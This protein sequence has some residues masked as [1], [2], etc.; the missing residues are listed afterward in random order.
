MEKVKTKEPKIFKC[1][2]CGRKMTVKQ[3]EKAI[4]YGCSN[5]GSIDIDADS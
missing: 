5:C 1:Q 2:E 4:S 3:A